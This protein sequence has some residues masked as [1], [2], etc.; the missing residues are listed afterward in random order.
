MKTSKLNTEET[1][2]QSSGCCTPTASV[3]EQN[4]PCCEQ[5]EDGSSCCDKTESKEVNSEKTGC[6]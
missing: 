2:T 5:P 3:K 6:C 4:T 1:T